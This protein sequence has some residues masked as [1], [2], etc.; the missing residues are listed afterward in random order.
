MFPKQQGDPAYIRF[1]ALGFRSLGLR[2]T[3]S[4]I[5]GVLE[6]LALGRKAEL[7]MN[8]SRETSGTRRSR[9]WLPAYLIR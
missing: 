6:S 4:V 8:C 2:K 3:Y 9:R 5:D 7:P 1:R